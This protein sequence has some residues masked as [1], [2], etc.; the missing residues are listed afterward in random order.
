[1]SPELT[2]WDHVTIVVALT[3]VA[4]YSVIKIRNILKPSSGG[5][6]GCSGGD[7]GIP[8]QNTQISSHSVSLESIHVKSNMNNSHED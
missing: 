8:S 1:M 6:D 4:I 3:F 7:C 5:C 2:F